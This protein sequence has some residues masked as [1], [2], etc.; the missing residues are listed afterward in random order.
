MF[1]FRTLKLRPDLTLDEESA[2][3][4]DD[5]RTSGLG[6]FELLCGREFTLSVWE[7]AVREMKVGELSRFHCPFKVRP[8]ACD[9]R[10]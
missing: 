8:V 6:P 3:V 4:V 10:N 5:S 2:E 1:N 9:V 7:E